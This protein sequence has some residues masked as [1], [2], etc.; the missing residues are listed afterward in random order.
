MYFNNMGFDP[1]A[2]R[3]AVCRD[4]PCRYLG[5]GEE[6]NEM[7]TKEEFFLGK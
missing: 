6:G 4:A 7:F 1:G 5:G 3:L 2:V